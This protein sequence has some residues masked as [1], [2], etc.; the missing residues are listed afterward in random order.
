MYTAQQA[1]K[2]SM[3]KS[4]HLAVL[5]S[6]NDFIERAA[7]EGRTK[8]TVLLDPKHVFCLHLLTK[9]LIKLGYSVSYAP[10]KSVKSITISWKPLNTTPWTSEQKIS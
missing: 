9:E 5:S 10:Q 4:G 3:Q 7:L 1:L 2:V 6:L 8:T